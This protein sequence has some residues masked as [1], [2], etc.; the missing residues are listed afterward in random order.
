MVIQH[1]KDEWDSALFLPAYS[2]Y[3]EHK[4]LPTMMQLLNLPTELMQM[5]LFY[6]ILAR[7]VK[8]GVRLRLVCSKF[9]VLREEVKSMRWMIS[10]WQ[11]IEKFHQHLTPVLYQTRL[12]DDFSAPQVGFHWQ[13][14][15]DRYGS[16]KLWHDYLVYRVLGEMN[17]DVGRFV[18]IREAAIALHNLV[19]TV[20]GRCLPMQDIIHGLCW[21]AL[22]R[23][24]NRP[25]ERRLWIKARHNVWNIFPTTVKRLRNS[26]ID[27]PSS[28]ELN[29]LCAAAYFDEVAVA[30]DLLQRNGDTC[31]S[32]HSIN[33]R[34]LATISCSMLG[35]SPL[36]PD[37]RLWAYVDQRS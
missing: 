23:G 5:I 2:S 4:S 27:Q 9:L 25:G 35:I 37:W 33:K 7:G 19:L 31:R 6:C 12:L 13:M 22:E 16:A 1:Y 36:S 17:R 21:L 24:T 8:R 14:R 29:L 26:F 32:V 3:N 34:A 11:Y 15:D 18:E 30:R 20:G 10:E 28:P